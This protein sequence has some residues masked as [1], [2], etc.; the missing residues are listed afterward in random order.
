[1]H[2]SKL[3]GQLFALLCVFC[4]RERGGGRERGS[5][6][7]SHDKDAVC[8]QAYIERAKRIIQ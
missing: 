5:L 8:F 7:L 6:L 2:R 3:L 4:E 1:M